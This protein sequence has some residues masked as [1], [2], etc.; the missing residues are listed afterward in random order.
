VRFSAQALAN[1]GR[2]HIHERPPGGSSPG[3]RLRVRVAWIRFAGPRSLPA[4]PKPIRLA[5]GDLLSLLARSLRRRVP[6]PRALTR[7][8]VA[9]LPLGRSATA[10]CPSS[11]SPSRGRSSSASGWCGD[12]VE[13][14]ERSLSPGSERPRL[15]YPEPR[16]A[17]NSEVEH[18][19]QCRGHQDHEEQDADGDGGAGPH[20]SPRRESST[21]VSTPGSSTAPALP[22]APSGT[23][24]T[25]LPARSPSSSAAEARS[26]QSA[27]RP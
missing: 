26:R 4:R 19:L 5:A 3:P 27:S 15:G 18:E 24:V 6:A 14:S 8:R 23:S 2:C 16:G 9:P 1:S 22:P 12:G 21:G 20:W 17:S 7:W 11:S 25:P 10:S 13:R